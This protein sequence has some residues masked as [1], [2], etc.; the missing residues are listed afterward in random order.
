VLSIKSED[1][2]DGFVT[3]L[4]TTEQF[5]SLI[6][7]EQGL[8]IALDGDRVIAYVMAASWH[9]WQHWP[10]FQ[11]MI[12]D[13]SSMT[14]LGQRLTVDNSY[15][16]GPI[17]IDSAYRSTEVLY[18]IF[19]FSRVQMA[20]R[21]PI[22][23]TFINHINPRS[24]T[25]HVD[26][27]GLEV[28]KSF[29]FNQN[30][31]YCLAYDTQKPVLVIRNERPEEQLEVENLVREAFWNHHG[32]G[33]DEHFLLHKLRS[34]ASFVNPLNL[35]ATLDNVVVGQIV[36]THAHI[37]S[38]TGITHQV[39]CFGPLSVLPEYRGLGIGA[40]LVRRSLSQAK[41]LGYRAVFIYGDPAYYKRFGFVAAEQYKIR[42]PDN[43]FADPLQVFPLYADAL[44]T[45]TGRFFEATAYAIKEEEAKAYDLN[46]IE[47]QTHTGL[48]SQ[49]R[50][51]T[52]IKMR[53]PSG[54]GEDKV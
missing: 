21:Y 18:E 12:S 29:P 1:K 6:N 27:L 26:K 31:Y 3:T 15:Q 52:L 23:V 42:T 25:A 17:C 13:L 50:F 5:E 39:L 46:F 28:L 7:L 20:K 49:L 43:H 8:T 41:R 10:L 16:Y 48:P 14:Y 34:D 33:C 4:F 11:H 2:K 30:Q 24:Y 36:Y 32:P 35:V 38:D 54:L 45:I 44:K 40:A 19:E 51:N 22:L 47:K 53:R 9:Y 37:Q